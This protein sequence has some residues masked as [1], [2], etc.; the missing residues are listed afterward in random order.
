KHFDTRLNQWINNEN[1]KIVDEPIL[2]EK[3]D[4]TLLELYFPDTPFSFGHI[5]EKSTVDDLYK[6]PDG[7]VLLLSSKS[8]LLYG[9]RECLE[10]IEKLCPDRKDRGAY[11][12]IL[13][14]SCKDAIYKEMNVLVVDDATGENGGI[15]PNGLAWRQVGDCHGKISPSLAL[16]LSETVEQVIQHRLGIPDQFRFAKGTLAPKNLNQL[17]Y[18]KGNPQL[19]LILPTSSFKGGDKKNNPIS[20]GLHQVK[21]WIGEKELS[22]LGKIATSQVHASFP[23]GIKDYL[24]D[25]ED[26]AKKLQDLQDDPRQLAQYFC[27]K[28]ETR[29]EV[30]DHNKNKNHANNYDNEQDAIESDSEPSKTN[31]Q[32]DDLIYRILKADLSSSHCQLLET[33][34]VSNLA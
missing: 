14:G 13:L 34:K 30:E 28:Y 23:E 27:D 10:T 4:N 15:L 29:Q 26:R 22:Q 25:L 5:D 7:H 33:Q 18:L 8:R 3:L 2:T 9:P 31:Q 19:D 11:G 1:P 16:E 32:N 21:V 6:H 17:P 24:K 12:S 20:P